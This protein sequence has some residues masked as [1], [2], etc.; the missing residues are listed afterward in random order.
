MYT[1]DTQAL[2][3][4]RVTPVNS[5]D[6]PGAGPRF[7]HSGINRMKGGH[8]VTFHSHL[9]FLAVLVDNDSLFILFGSAYYYYTTYS[10]SHMLKR[11]LHVLDISNGY[12]W[13]PYI[14]SDY[15]RPDTSVEVA[16]WK[17]AVGVCIG[18]TAVV[19]SY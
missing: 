6:A 19:S 10:P 5:T 1:F 12:A 14:P 3:F 2:E 13:K 4:K 11:E 17:V 15:N 9:Q 7:G 18:L 8:P 16:V